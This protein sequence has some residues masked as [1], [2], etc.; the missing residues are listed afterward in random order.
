[1]ALISTKVGDLP[2]KRRVYLPFRDHR[3]HRRVMTYASAWFAVR[4][5]ICDNAVE[6]RVQLPVIDALRVCERIVTTLEAD[7][8][9]ADVAAGKLSAAE[10]AEHVR[11]LRNGMA[12]VRRSPG[13]LSVRV[14]ERATVQ[15][16]QEQHTE[17]VTK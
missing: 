8:V 6:A 7:A 5:T 9:V 2:N 13:S 14:A 1:M 4:D 15:R 17:E 12:M 11:W 3:K 16:V 10:A